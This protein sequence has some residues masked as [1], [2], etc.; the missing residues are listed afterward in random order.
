MKLIWVLHFLMVA[1]GQDSGQYTQTFHKDIEMFT[2]FSQEFLSHIM[3]CTIC[4]LFS[5]F[6][7]ENVTSQFWI[8]LQ[9][10]LTK[11]FCF[12][13]LW[14]GNEQ[15]LKKVVCYIENNG[16]QTHKLFYNNIYLKTR[17]QNVDNWTLNKATKHF[18]F[19]KPSFIIKICCQ[20]ICSI[21]Y[22]KHLS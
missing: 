1:P 9:R 15:S 17:Q 3:H 22:A 14:S 13:Y 20:S 8:L 6:S 5:I 10:F 4:Q 21:L 7:L 11:Y 16:K 12:Y 19:L 18:L 2:S